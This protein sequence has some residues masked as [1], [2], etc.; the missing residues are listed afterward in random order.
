MENQIKR[1]FRVL[2]GP[3]LVLVFVLVFIGLVF[4]EAN[5]TE[6]SFQVGLAFAVAG[7]LV[8]IA[9][10]GYAHRPDGAMVIAGPYRF[11]RNPIF[12]GTFLILLGACTAARAKIAAIFM[13]VG[14]MLFFGRA[15]RAYDLRNALKM[16]TAY[17]EYQMLVSAF[18]PNL[19]PYPT[20]GHDFA[21]FSLTYSLFRR[22]RL[23]LDITLFLGI[24]YA[25]FFCLHK[26]PEIFSGI[27]WVF[28]FAM[29]AIFLMRSF[30]GSKVRLN[31][32]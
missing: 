28:A 15:C 21:K 29:M 17:K 25:I 8:R 22:G 4:L 14:V 32:E 13:L 1:W 16:G 27:K 11:V 26:W 3:K 20:K 23:E 2:L 12:F 10:S 24:G 7:Q 30:L 6:T 31:F 5:P 19:F 18:L 9:A